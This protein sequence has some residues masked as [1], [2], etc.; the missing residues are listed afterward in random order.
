MQYDNNIQTQDTLS[1]DVKKLIRIGWCGEK[2]C[3]LQLEEE[4][5]MTMLGTN[6]EKE[7]FTG[8][9]QVCGKDTDLPAYF[10]NT[11]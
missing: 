7:D 11:Y 5:D 9:C 2:E 3:G 6:R 8:K 4:L 1:T 10:A